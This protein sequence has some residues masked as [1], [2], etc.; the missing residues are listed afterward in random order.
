M[1]PDRESPLEGPL[2]SED[3]VWEVRVVSEGQCEVVAEEYVDPQVGDE[4]VCGGPG[5]HE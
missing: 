3:L 1:N 5:V 4:V 2:G